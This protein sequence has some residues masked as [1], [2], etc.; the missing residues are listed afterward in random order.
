MEISKLEPKGLWEAFIELSAIPRGSKKEQK[1]IEFVR[2]QAIKNKLSSSVDA[3]GNVVVR[4]PASKEFQGHSTIILQSHLD[5]VHQKNTDTKFD[6]ESQGIQMYLEQDWVKARGTTL[7]ADNGIGVAAILAILA[8]DKLKHPP[9]EALFTVD[10]EKGMGGARYLDAKM[11]SGK[12]LLNLDSEQD[13]E[14]TIGCAGGIN[15]TAI[16]TYK[17]RNI[18][19]KCGFQ[20]YIKGLS[21]GHSGVD[22][23]LGRGN[24]NKLIGRILYEIAQKIPI[25][26][27]EIQGG[28]LRNAL[29]REAFAIIGISKKNEQ[30]FRER[31]EII[32]NEIA[33]EFKAKDPCLEIGCKK[34]EVSDTFSMQKRPQKALL[35]SLLACTDGVLLMSPDVKGLTETSS[36]FSKISVADGRIY[37]E[38]MQRSCIDSAKN[39]IAK[40]FGAAFEAMD[41][42]VEHDGS[43][44]GWI[45]DNKNPLLPVMIARYQA[46]F[47]TKPKISATHGGLECSFLKKHLPNTQMISFGPT[48]EFP[49]SPDERVSVSSVQK[50]W[51]Y[52]TDVLEHLTKF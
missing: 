34:V 45:P 22:I 11:L 37:I 50:F 35:R 40:S 24:A 47:N 16:G 32:S 17:K 4:K 3:A 5:M 23:H 21:G 20:V 44:P 13:D 10:E 49:H 28:T 1:A 48:I 9:I 43:Y 39:Y 25:R 8:C 51:K 46:L 7:G 33:K 52:L 18:G 36:N 26:I 27:I 19:E 41:L 14:L 42:K 2:N 30:V 31:I 6:F 38:S 12:I 29:P 15:T